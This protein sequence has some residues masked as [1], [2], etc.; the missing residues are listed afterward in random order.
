MMINSSRVLVLAMLSTASGWGLPSHDPR[1]LLPLDPELNYDDYG[2]GRGGGNGGGLVSRQPPAPRALALRPVPASGL[3]RRFCAL[4]LSTFR[5]QAPGPRCT[6][7]TTEANS[8][9]GAYAAENI[10][11]TFPKITDLN[12]VPFTLE[13]SFVN[14]GQPRH[15][16]GGAFEGSKF[17]LQRTSPSA[18]AGA[19]GD[20]EWCPNQNYFLVTA[21]GVTNTLVYT[22]SCDHSW[23]VSP[24]RACPVHC[25][26]VALSHCPCLPHGLP[27]A[28][29]L[30]TGSGLLATPTATPA[31]TGPGCHPL[32][33]HALALPLPPRGCP[34]PPPSRD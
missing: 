13:L 20:I 25:P 10:A 28:T 23:S 19:P 3:Y 8:P 27:A 4:S 26:C 33:L 30:V 22:P 32:P 9:F 7:I 14:G 5:A 12:D 31:A 17:S 6:G 15:F 2:G 24:P 1:Q 18:G 16:T 29:G 11:V 21:Y 34:S